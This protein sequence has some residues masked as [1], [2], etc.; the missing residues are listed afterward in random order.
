MVI[1]IDGLGVNGKSTLARMIS[2]E[3]GFKNF[4]TG[5]IYRCIALEIIDKNLDVE[6]VEE[7]LKKISYIN[8]DFDDDKVI[9]NDRDVTTEIRTEKISVLSTK[10]ATIP[11]IKQIVREIQINFI[12]NNDTVIEGRDIATRIAPWADIKFY[13]YSNFETR[14]KRLWKQNPKVDI[15]EVRK[16]LK[17]RDELDINR[18]NFVKPENAIEIDT[19]DKNVNEV[20]EIMI[21]QINQIFKKL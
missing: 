15:E 2:Q 14:V 16:N 20:F 17:I 11:E 19:T 13:L 3:I 7:L 12:K 4:N 1:A 18:G 21:D 6:N 8:V 5:A 10:W 9:L